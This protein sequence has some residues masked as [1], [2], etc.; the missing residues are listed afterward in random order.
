MTYQPQTSSESYGQST[1]PKRGNRGL[2]YGLI[3]GGIV[4]VLA[5]AAV[6]GVLAYNMLQRPSSIPQLLG[7]DTQVYATLTPNISD[8]PNIQ[9]L[10]KAY[11][12]LFDSQNPADADK[13]LEELLGVKF[14]EDVT[15]WIGTEM[16]VGVSGLKDFPVNSQTMDSDAMEKFAEQVKITFILSSRDDAKAQA[17][18]DKQRTHRA[19][20][21]EQF[22]E[23]SHKNTKI[24]AQRDSK[25]SPITAFA[26]VK[27]HVVF[28]SNADVIK[29]M[30]DRDGNGTDTLEKN[31][32]FNSI[33][34][35]LPSTAVGYVFVDGTSLSELTSKAVEEQ[36]Q[37]MPAAQAQQLETQMQSLDA[38]QGM[39]LSLS[40]VDTG[41]QF[42]T[43]V[44][45]DMSK[46]NNELQAQIE[47]T[48]KPVDGALVQSIHSDAIGLVTFKIPS[49]FK[50]QIMDAIKAQPDG[51]VQL[52]Q[53]EQQLGIN[54]EKDLLD[55]FVGDASLV[56]LPGEKL[57]DVTIPATGYFSLRP[58]DKA[59]A[60]AGMEKI[61][62]ALEQVAASMAP[63]L[64]FESEQVAGSDWQVVKEPS[65]QQPVGGYGFVKDDLVIAFGMRAMEGASGGSAKPVSNDESFKT[66]STK[67]ANPNGGIF[68]VNMGSVLTLMR[69]SGIDT[70]FA[71]SEAEKNLKPIKAIGAAGEPG[72]DAKG[73]ARARLFVYISE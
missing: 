71:G 60:E 26:L 73:I 52:Q 22:D 23:I 40:V 70:E 35:N 41:V 25:N 61:A 12:Q 9:R 14:Q 68:Y 56:I 17:F 37:M 32:N 49:S 44:A 58:Q 19:D 67:L 13:Q 3:G 24:F 42:D 8:I 57:G 43:T 20:Q 36:L 28:A 65:S 30:I 34:A 31:A 47:E 21:G 15:P 64:A 59:A 4:V 6:V 55:W 18:L 27:K 48:R 33:K 39:G 63:G 66:V 62:T 5:I 45:F 69:D 51:E 50:K 11:P 53:V 72:I 7:A 1:P 16:A 38:L 29:A 10:Q 54:L 2:L 46:L